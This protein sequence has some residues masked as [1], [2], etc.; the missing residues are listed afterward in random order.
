MLVMASIAA[1]SSSPPPG[2]DTAANIF[3]ALPNLFAILQ[4][5]FIRNTPLEGYV[6][7]FGTVVTMVGYMGSGNEMMAESGTSA[8]LA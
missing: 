6:L 2:A 3:G 7:L 8:G 5:S 4:A 1:A